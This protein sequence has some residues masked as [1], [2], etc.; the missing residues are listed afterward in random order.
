MKED[1]QTIEAATTA[2]GTI[3]GQ[4]DNKTRRYDRQ[5]RLWAASGQAALENARILVISGSATSTS[6][7]KN[8]V[9]PGIGHF[10]ILDHTKVTPEDAGNNFF[11]EGPSS[12]GKSRAEEAVRLLLELNEG[13]EGK[14]D[15]RDIADVLESDP[16]YI[17]SFSL[18]IA[19]NLHPSLLDK[20]SMLLWSDLLNPSL[21]VV[22]SAGFLAEF[23][24][25]YHEHAIIESHTETAPSLRLDKP[26]PELLE[27]ATSLNFD[28]MDVTDHGHVP[29]V[30][31]LVHLMERWKKEHNDNPPKTY[32]E[33]KQ[34]K[35]LILGMKKK[36]DEENF[37][38]AETQTYRSWTETTVPSDVAALFKDPRLSSLTPQSPPFFRLLAAL[39]E[40]TEQ[41]PY[42]LPLTST[43]PDM[44]ANTTSYIHLQKLYK[45]RSEE[46][47]ETFKKHLKV[48]VDDNMVDVF[49][50]NAHGLKLLKGKRWGDVA[51]N[52]AELAEKLNL[53]A[54]EVSTHLALSA[55]RTASVK[56]QG[57]PYTTELLTAE[58]QAILP[59]G[60]ELPKAFN[61]AVGELV[62][63]PDADLPNTAA[64]LGGLV[65]QEAIKIITKQY[66]P[67]NG[68][69]VID[70]IES[71]TGTI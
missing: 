68:C 5:L 8:L 50:K 46:E 31:I 45:K 7:L 20:L 53:Q 26:F 34:F 4:P 30:V 10:T 56:Y 12:I 32:D 51:A 2:V 40:F 71:W 13:V 29:Y 44:K 21:I 15:N 70:L 54:K 59:P 3:E 24:I 48:P 33:K 28:Q 35:S 14:A 55:S 39:K 42:V 67:I 49:V 16:S 69:C 57:K 58:A 63:A 36:I 60:I 17:T 25:Q 6:I 27:Y 38:E 19:H 9:L 18:V 1:S 22:N 41:P 52:G 61:H 65:A 11:L 62:R 66:V 43:L 37:D 47:K 64:F 23:F